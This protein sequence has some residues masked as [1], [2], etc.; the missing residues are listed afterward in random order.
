MPACPGRAVHPILRAKTAPESKVSLLFGLAIERKQ[1]PR[2]V[3][4]L[5]VAVIWP[6]VAR[7]DVDCES[8]RPRETL[9]GIRFALVSELLF[10]HVSLT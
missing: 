4:E 3:T 6:K 8:Y 9:F 1:I 7:R 5:K 2:S 10:T